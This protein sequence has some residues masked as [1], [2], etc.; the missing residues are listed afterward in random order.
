MGRAGSQFSVGALPSP[1]WEVDDAAWYVQV[2][3]L[4]VG[5]DHVQPHVGRAQA[6]ARLSRGEDQH[7]PQQKDF[8]SD[9]E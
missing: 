5:A 2:V 7:L 6:V 1:E 4:S 8:Q 3:S 9:F